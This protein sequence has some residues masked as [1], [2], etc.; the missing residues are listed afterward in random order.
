MWVWSLGSILKSLGVSLASPITS[1]GVPTDLERPL[2][3]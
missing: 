3:F 1:V 2:V